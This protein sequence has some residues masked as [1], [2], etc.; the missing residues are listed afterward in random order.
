MLYVAKVLRWFG[1]GRHCEIRQ[2]WANMIE[3]DTQPDTPVVYLTHLQAQ[4]SW[5]SGTFERF[6]V[7]G[8]IRQDASVIVTPSDRRALE[9]GHHRGAVVA[10]EVY[11]VTEKLLW[12]DLDRIAALRVLE[13]SPVHAL[14]R[15]HISQI[16]DSLNSIAENYLAIR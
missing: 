7:S 15:Q 14:R 4:A 3:S 13:K 8:R 6:L 1:G 10:R 16:L 2:Q 5:V 11:T 9:E 12:G